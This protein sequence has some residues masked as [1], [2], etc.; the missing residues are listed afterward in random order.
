SAFSSYS[1][2]RQYRENI[3]EA[4]RL[5]GADAPQ[6][7]K[8]RMFF[9]HPLFIDVHRQRVD[10]ALQTL[11]AEQRGAAGLVFTAHS[12]P[13][14]MAGGCE[15]AAQLR[16]SCRLVSEAV[17]DGANGSRR[18]DL[19]FQSRS[20]PPQVPWLEPDV[21]DH[22]RENAATLSETGVVVVPVGF[23]SDHLEVLYDLDVE[24]ANVCRDLRIPFARSAT[25]GDHPDFVRM[26][27]DLVDER[28]TGRSERAAIGLLP[29][30]HDVC[31]ENCCPLGTP[32]G[33]PPAADQPREA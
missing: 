27:V 31:P 8:L 18:W 1:G 10:E 9:N 22:L 19:V 7:D 32:M 4:R 30:S 11:P 15:Y 29:A 24:A 13:L 16:E 20:G 21:C 2:C 28:I 26:I 14:S 6:V 5:A 3:A 33:R 25:P 17:G 23:V 12:I